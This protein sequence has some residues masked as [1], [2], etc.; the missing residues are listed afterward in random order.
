M[1]KAKTMGVC[2]L[3]IFI[4]ISKVTQSMCSIGYSMVF[5]YLAV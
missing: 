4:G 3:A 1:T 2:F 5:K